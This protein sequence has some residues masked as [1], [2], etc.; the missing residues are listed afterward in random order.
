MLMT[1]GIKIFL[2]LEKNFL[3]NKKFGFFS[4]CFHYYE[5]VRKFKAFTNKKL[6]SGYILDDLLKDYFVKLS[7]IIFKRKL[8][9]NYKFN[10][11]YNIIGDYDFIIKISKNLKGWVFKKN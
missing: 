2:F 6:P 9:K 10:P 8:L 4:N 1:G 7:T 5:N 3:S 11:R